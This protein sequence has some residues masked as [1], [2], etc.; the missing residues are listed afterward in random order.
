MRQMRILRRY[1]RVRRWCVGE[2][3]R[4]SLPSLF[5]CLPLLV[6]KQFQQHVS[7]TRQGS[8]YYERDGDGQTTH[9]T[10]YPC[11]PNPVQSIYSIEVASCS[12]LPSTSGTYR[13]LFRGAEPT[14]PSERYTAKT[15]A[16]LCSVCIATATSLWV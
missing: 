8:R 11:V 15:I 14:H 6:T 4:L 7:V 3:S 2:T 10:L 1:R 12:S 16:H 5:R 13:A 9:L